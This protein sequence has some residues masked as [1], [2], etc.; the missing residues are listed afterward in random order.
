MPMAVVKGSLK[1]C[2][3]NKWFFLFIIIL[4]LMLEY[5]TDII[6]DPVYNCGTWIFSILIMGYGLQIIQDV[7]RGGT[8]LPKI[9]PKK[10]IILGLKGT[11]INVFY[12]L[13]QIGILVLIASALNFPTFDLEDFFLE[14]HKTLMLIYHHDAVSFMIF[15]IS[16]IIVTYVTT[17]FM[18]LSLA[19][20]ADGENLRHLF[21]FAQIK[22]EID[23]IGWKKYTIAYTKIILVIIVFSHINKFIDPYYGFN[24]IIGTFSSF[25]AFIVEYRGMGRIYKVYT[26]N[27]DKIT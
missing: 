16:G 12:L 11:I 18:E 13:I 5:V 27:K 10:V 4:F 21:N 6:D 14:Y 23:I 7:I 17:F 15:T 1:Y 2:L 24:V 19:R 3:K 20:L 26:D 25:F 9:L 22:H 8:C